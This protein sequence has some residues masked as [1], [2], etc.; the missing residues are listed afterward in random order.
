M[1]LFLTQKKTIVLSLVFAFASLTSSYSQSN[2][3][4]WE[5]DQAPFKTGYIAGM[6]VIKSDSNNVFFYC[7]T[8]INREEDRVGN[9]VQKSNHFIVKHDKRT[10]VNTSVEIN[11]KV[12][13][14]KL[15]MLNYFYIDNA[16]HVFTY[17]QNRKQK[18]LYVFHETFNVDKLESNNDINKVAEID[19][20]VEKGFYLDETSLF[21]VYQN[22]HFLFRYSCSTSRGKFF[23]LEVLDKKL[24]REWGNYSMALTEVGINFESGY[25]IDK[26]GNVY[27][28][29][30]NFEK[31]KDV[32][33][34]FDRSR[35]WVVCYPKG[36]GEPRSMVMILKDDNFITSEQLTVNEKGNPICA[37][38]YSK[39]GTTSAVGAFS[40]VLEPLLAKIIS[41]N[42]K[43]FAPSLV[44]KGLDDKLTNVDLK[45]IINKKD[46][47]N[48]FFYRIDSIHFRKDG[49]FDLVA[50]KYKLIIETVRTQNGVTV[51]YYHYYDDLY[52]LNYN[53]DGSVRW[54]QKIPKY[55]YVI[56]LDRL[57]GGYFLSYDK[58]ENMNFIFNITNE[59]QVF[60]K[61]I[62]EAKTVSI[63]LDKD[64]NESFK[65][66][67][68]DSKI[69]NIICPVY[70]FKQDDNT[71]IITR[72]QY[73]NAPINIGYKY[74]SLTFGELKNK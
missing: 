12:N 60:L 42:L 69:A 70:C 35:V 21:V 8:D 33:K 55:E 13:E 29:Q 31:E 66:L 45:K 11:L 48:D 56:D 16:F 62:R 58:D 25:Q 50:Q 22:N 23:G 38:L 40:F 57:I 28:I 36:G 37:G 34:H 51:T 39:P 32:Y 44:T 61:L 59:K 2:A 47:E 41:V 19:L 18:K 4:A 71:N 43:E 53:G 26:D 3:I 67:V 49:S 52:V 20:K 15:T 14:F 63:R 1:K 17:Y 73:L 9:L 64:G 46:F 65:E 30:R 54:V 10:A 6:Q 7:N 68:S 5:A 27:A 24:N 72:F 74:N